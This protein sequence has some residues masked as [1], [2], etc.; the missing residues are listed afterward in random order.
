MACALGS[1]ILLLATTTGEAVARFDGAHALG[2]VTCLAFGPTG[3]HLFSGG[4]DGHVRTWEYARDQKCVHRHAFNRE[5]LAVCVAP[6]DPTHNTLYL[7]LGQQLDAAS[8]HASNN[9]KGEEKKKYK[10]IAYQRPAGGGGGGGGQETKLFTL[11]NRPFFVQ[12]TPDGQHLVTASAGRLVV[13]HVADKEIAS[14]VLFDDRTPRDGSLLQ[15]VA[16]HPTKSEIATGDVNG[17]VYL[18]HTLF[19]KLGTK[20]KQAKARPPKRGGLHHLKR[21]LFRSEVKRWHAHGVSCLAFTPDGHYLLSGGEEA[22]LVV[23]QV[24]KGGH[25]M[26]FL[27]RLGSRLSTISLNQDGTQCALTTRGN[28]LRLADP[29]GLKVRWEYM[30]LAHLP[31]PGGGLV[32]MSAA[33]RLWAAP[34]APATVLSNCLPGKLQLYDT[35]QGSVTAEVEVVTSNVVSRGSEAQGE[36]MVPPWVT[37]AA[38]SQDGRHLATVEARVGEEGIKRGSLK[39][40]ERAEQPHRG[41]GG[42]GGSNRRGYV[43]SSVVDRPHESQGQGRLLALAYHP[44]LDLVASC[45]SEG[46]F[47]LW[48]RVADGEEEEDPRD[49]HFHWTCQATVP[50]Q[51]GASR[52]LAFAGDGT[53]LAVGCGRSIALWDPL[54]VRLMAMLVDPLQGTRGEKAEVRHLAFVPNTPR[55]VVATKTVVVVWDLLTVTPVQRYET[56]GVVHLSV[57]SPVGLAQSFS[58]GEGEGEKVVHFAAVLQGAEDAVLLSGS[59][60]AQQHV[61]PQQS[62]VLFNAFEPTPLLTQAVERRAGPVL[63]VAFTEGGVCYM[64]REGVSLLGPPR[65]ALPRQLRHKR[66]LGATA[67]AVALEAGGG[68]RPR[69]AVD[70]AIAAGGGG[71]EKK[72]PKPVSVAELLGATTGHLPKPSAVFDAF[73]SGLLPNAPIVP[74]SPTLALPL[75]PPTQTTPRNKAIPNAKHSSS[76]PPPQPPSTPAAAA[77]APVSVPLPAPGVKKDLLAMLAAG[78]Q[79]QGEKKKPQQPEDDEEEEEEDAAPVMNGKHHPEEEEK[80]K[81]DAA[82]VVNHTPAAKKKGSSSG[83]SNSTPRPVRASVRKKPATS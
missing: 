15:A 1:S 41:G 18:W 35:Q 73:L 8:L 57:P 20:L 61:Q 58:A 45:S 64:T 2:G 82:V 12:A 24:S 29:L 62:L 14:E 27:P 60:K 63:S 56:G 65:R 4:K 21:R 39:F 75:R 71:G 34:H 67:A 66:V 70:T 19:T 3:H 74:P 44:T 16:L 47:S 40:W 42:G 48:A 13:W 28:S 33:A 10:V 77:A 51:R 23:C 9:K 49:R 32:D 22:V 52:C 50:F 79:S 7:A 30:G 43:L 36:R 72:Q 68:K 76:H 59:K 53:L 46:A 54:S 17:R 69:L 37:H 55:L 31:E 11:K 6:S 78:F 80:E 83:K 25:P 81:E 5:I 38:M 26:T